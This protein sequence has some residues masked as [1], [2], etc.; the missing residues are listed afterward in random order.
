LKNNGAWVGLT[1]RYDSGL[2]AGAVPDFATA[3]AFTPAEQAAIGLFCG[4]VFATQTQG[5]TSCSDPNQGA[6][7]IVIPA[8]GTENDDKNPPRIAPRHLFDVGAGIDNLFRT[9][10]I[11]WNARFTVVNLTNDVALY[12]FQSTFSGTHF[13]SPRAYTAQLGFTF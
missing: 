10:R 13:V 12:N 4:N 2:V 7:R 9:D 1:W 6:T 8:P 11:K 3:L 5:I